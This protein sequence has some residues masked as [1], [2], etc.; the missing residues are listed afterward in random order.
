MEV[1]N[2]RVLKGNTIFHGKQEKCERT[3]AQ[4]YICSFAFLNIWELL[5]ATPGTGSAFDDHSFADASLNSSEFGLSA[6][7]LWPLEPDTGAGE[8]P[9]CQDNQRPKHYDTGVVEVGG[10]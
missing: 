3:D 8:P 10:R 4:Y 1:K 7:N 2:A 5:S 9:D 6:L